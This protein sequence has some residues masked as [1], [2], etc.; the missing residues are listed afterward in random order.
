MLLNFFIYIRIIVLSS[1][2][3]SKKTHTRQTQA[4]TEQ[5][6]NVQKTTCI[7]RKCTPLREKRFYFSKM[8]LHT[9]LQFID[10][11]CTCEHVNFMSDLIQSYPRCCCCCQALQLFLPISVKPGNGNHI[12]K[13]GQAAGDHGK[14][15]LCSELWCSPVCGSDGY[16]CFSKVCCPVC[17]S[18]CQSQTH[19]VVSLLFFDSQSTS[20]CV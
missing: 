3:W 20:Q 11:M 18:S 19:I 6:Q 10:Y 13:H 12:H 17:F 7:S 8:M 5:A 2:W 14:C 16:T 9:I 1:S 4:S 15:R